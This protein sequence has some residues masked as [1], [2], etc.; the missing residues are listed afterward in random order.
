MSREG[1]LELD[2]DIRRF[3][4]YRPIFSSELQRRIRIVQQVQ[5]ESSFLPQ[6]HPILAQGPV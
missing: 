2:A 1:G 3:L 5:G 4:L 6:V